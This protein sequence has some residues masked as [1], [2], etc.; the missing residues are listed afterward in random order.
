[1]D[2]SRELSVAVVGLGILGSR[3]ARVFHENERTRLAAVVDVSLDRA[4]AISEQYQV[5]YYGAV[6]EMLAQVKP[7][8]VA[9]ATPDDAHGEPVLSA[10]EAGAH[11]F[12]E[13][14]LATDKE[15]SL[16]IVD[17]ARRAKRLAVVNYSQRF[18]ADFAWIKQLVDQGTIGKPVMVQ[19][20]K[21]DKLSV[22]TRMIGWAARTSPFFFMTSHDLDLVSWYLDAKPVEV[23]AQDVS[24]TLSGLGIKVHDG[25]QAVLRFDSGAS[26]A[27]H[28]SWI[29]P[30]TYPTVAGGSLEIVGTRGYL[31]YSMVGR[32]AELYTPESSQVLEFGGL[33]TADERDG[34]IEGAFTRSVNSFLAAVESG[35]EP[36]TSVEK[37]LAVTM[38]QCAVIESLRTNSVIRVSEL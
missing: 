1:M 36:P 6:E 9:V 31:R 32:K 30:E 22:P 12:V 8:V 26:A 15:T 37:T 17:T 16:A 11:V 21:F 4:K 29:H 10:L 35:V 5:P 13:K 18:A 2:A 34:R 28:S 38:A 19:S 3:H 27:F 14:P 7:D 25:V 33:H 23:Y 24:G 20:Q